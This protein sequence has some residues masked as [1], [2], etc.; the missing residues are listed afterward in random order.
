[1]L[2][3]L[4]PVMLLLMI[5]VLIGRVLVAADALLGMGP[6]AELFICKVLPLPPVIV[7]VIGN[8]AAAWLCTCT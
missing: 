5:T 4:Y 6:G 8:T 7:V 3:L 1:M 2:R